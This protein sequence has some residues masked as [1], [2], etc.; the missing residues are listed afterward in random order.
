METGEIDKVKA[1]SVSLSFKSIFLSSLFIFLFLINLNFMYAF[2]FEGDAVQIIDPIES[3]GAIPINI[4]D[5]HTRALDIPFIK[6]NAIPTTLS[7]AATVEDM[8]ITV[9]STTGF[10]DDVVV[11]IA[12]D[13]D[14]YIGRQLGAPIGNVILLD[15][16]IDVNYSAGSIVFPANYHMNVD[17]SVTPQIFQIGAVGRNSTLELDITRIM[18]YFQ[19]GT[20]MDDSKFGGI[21][22]LTNG[23]VL[24]RSDGVMT[25][26]WNAKSNG[27]ISLMTFDFQYTDKA[28]AGSYGARF[29]NT[30]A[31]QSKHGVTIR[32][33]PGDTL[34][35]IVQDDL[36]DLE[37]FIMMAQGHVVTN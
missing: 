22:T 27:E 37:D 10:A 24:R 32:L 12:M 19:D 4:Q 36:T 17:G 6:A 2:N 26:I 20:V 33:E 7:V 3:N 15:T 16:P 13:E 14:F 1:Q 5:Q 25:N 23:I 18:G 35:L 31:G 29:R 30:F 34:E 11:V 9:T 28:P 8:N 21:T